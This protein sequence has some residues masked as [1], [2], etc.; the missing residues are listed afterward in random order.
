[1]NLSK[2]NISFRAV[3]L[4]DVEVLLEWENDVSTWHLSNTLIPFSR[5]DMEQY[6]MNA[7]KDL[8]ASKQLRLMIDFTEDVKKTTIGCI[9]LFDFEPKHKRAGIGI[10]IAEKFR[11]KGHASNSLGLLTEYAFSVLNLH[12]LYC[13][14]ETDNEKSLA[15]FQSK[16]FE[17]VGLKRDW[18]FKSDQWVG[19]YLLQK[20]NLKK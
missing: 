20:I 18:N 11:K 5:F 17:I 16:G 6:V 8:F 9:D 13:N 12:Q 2:E 3:E 1:M 19:E 14:I 15:L 10:L 4:S 7:G